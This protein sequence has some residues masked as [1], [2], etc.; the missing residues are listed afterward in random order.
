MCIRD[1]ITINDVLP[2]ILAAA[3]IPTFDTTNVDGINQWAFLKNQTTT[4]TPNFITHAQ[5][6]E[7]FYNDNWKLLVPNNGAP[8]LYQLEEDPTETQ[9][10]ATQHPDIVR[11]LLKELQDFPRGEAVNDP[12][13]KAFLDPDIFG[14]DKEDR[15]PYA[16]VEG[17]LSGPSQLGYYVT[18]LFL[19]GMVFFIRWRKKR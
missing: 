9:N 19:L 16:G 3:G 10:V 6:G 7:A 5:F 2:T 4:I 17:T 12:L 1:R 13:W 14:G 11:V 18:P 8:E 15:A